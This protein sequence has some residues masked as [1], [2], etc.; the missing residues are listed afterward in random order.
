MAKVASKGATG[1]E[2]RK[3]KADAG[4]AKALDKGLKAMFQTL[5][6]RPT[7]AHLRETADQLEASRKDKGK[8]RRS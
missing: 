3:R 6:Q 7:P 5:E 1:A 2:L 8:D 4:K